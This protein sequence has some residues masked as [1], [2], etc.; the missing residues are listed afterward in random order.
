MLQLRIKRYLQPFLWIGV[1]NVRKN[2]KYH[3]LFTE[4]RDAIYIASP[5]GKLL[6][7]NPSFC[8]VF[9]LNKK[10]TIGKLNMQQLYADPG[11]ND[12]IRQKI[13]Q[14]GFVR[15]Y[16]VKLRK[17]NGVVMDC[18]VTATDRRSQDDRMLGYQ[19]I[20]RDIT[21]RKH[22]EK[23]IQ[24]SYLIQSIINQLLR[25]SLENI[26]LKEIL[27]QFIELITSIP[28]LSLQSRGSIFLTDSSMDILTMKASR[29]LTRAHLRLCAQVPYG[30]CLCGRA[31]RSGEIVFADCI[32]ERHEN[33]YKPMAPHGHYCVPIISPAKKVVGV[34]NLYLRVNHRRDRKEE[35]FLTAAASALA[36]IIE[37]KQTEQRLRKRE[38]ELGIKS[39]N[40]EEANIAL[41]L[42]LK[43]QN[44]DKKELEE[45]ILSNVK[46]L[47]SP[48][49]CKLKKS[50]LNERQMAY[51]DILE[52]NLDDI[53][54]PFSRRLSGK[55]LNLTPAE[56]RVANLVRQGKTTKEIAG[57]LNLASRTIG[58]HRESI[59]KK[60]RIK[61]KKINLRSYLLSL[62]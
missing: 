62:Q 7:T 24:Q 55:Y 34:I 30:R 61:N 11:D 39:K 2:K 6:G 1:I 42:L 50:G 43:S 12:R 40:L 5:A 46:E 33:R 21:E 31:A 51:T 22:I 52:S 32:D 57:L 53:V 36:G 44:E 41:R 17:K 9:G 29:E 10:E 27:A 13:N 56:I 59:R 35:E 8:K 4:S 26:S 20:I 14:K 19:S 28:W 3:T 54:S 16:E 25:V 58:A 49:I 15:D 38:R 47:V 60:L 48:Y 37:R 18:L 45:K 23:K